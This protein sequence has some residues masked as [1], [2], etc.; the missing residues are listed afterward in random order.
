[1]IKLVVGRF[2]V[3]LACIVIM[4]IFVGDCRFF[5]LPAPQHPLV[6]GYVKPISRTD[7]CVVSPLAAKVHDV[8]EDTLIQSV[9]NDDNDV[10]IMAVDSGLDLLFKVND[11][12]MKCF[13]SG[14]LAPLTIVDCKKDKKG[15][16]D[17]S[18]PHKVYV[19]TL[20]VDVVAYKYTKS[21][22]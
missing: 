8:Y 16:C 18:Q 20:P 15:E 14:S 5:R 6:N 1:M 12:D 11:K 3:F 13:R 21:A 10:Q 9:N 22:P 2:L 7:G 19:R 17:F 4:A